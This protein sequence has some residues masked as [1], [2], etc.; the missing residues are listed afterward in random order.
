MGVSDTGFD[1]TNCLLS[2]SVDGNGLGTTQ[3]CT[4]CTMDDF[5]SDGY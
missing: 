4:D 1:A 5:D 2:N 3:L